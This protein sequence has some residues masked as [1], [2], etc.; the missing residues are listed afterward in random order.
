MPE[1]TPVWVVMPAD[2]V[3]RADEKVTVAPPP[4]SPLACH[5]VRSVLQTG[6]AVTSL[7]TLAFCGC[8]KVTALPLR[9]MLEIPGFGEWADG[10]ILLQD[11][12]NQVFYRNI[13]IR[14][15]S[16]K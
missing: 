7:A 16:K 14:D 4:A 10:H 13:K 11:H 5:W 1:I 15:F 9:E 8:W 6:T 3:F 12:G 2:G